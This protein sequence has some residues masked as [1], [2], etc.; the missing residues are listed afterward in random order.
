[1]AHIG[2]DLRHVEAGGHIQLAL[3][4]EETPNASASGSATAQTVRPAI[5]S[6]SSFFEL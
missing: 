5:M 2:V 6:A 1:M 4:P 3:A